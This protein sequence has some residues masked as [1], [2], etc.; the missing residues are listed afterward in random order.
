MCHC[1]FP[2]ISDHLRLRLP[3]DV[4]DCID[5]GLLMCLVFTVFLYLWGGFDISKSSSV[6]SH[7]FSLFS[8]DFSIVPRPSLSPAVFGCL[9]LFRLSMFASVFSW[10]GSVHVCV[11]FVRL[12]LSPLV[13]VGLRPSPSPAVF[14]YLGLLRC[15]SFVFVFPIRLR[16]SLCFMRSSPCFS[17]RLRSSPFFSVVL[18]PSP[19]PDVSDVVL[20][21][22]V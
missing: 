3:P 5:F 21:V 12:R 17:V 1:L 9:G 14:G 2:F 15:Y 20:F 8:L 18:R 16:P 10:F 4:S 11:L 19:L 22:S 13:S 7:A 6:F